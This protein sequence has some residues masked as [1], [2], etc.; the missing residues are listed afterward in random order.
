MD[1]TV[2]LNKLINRK[3]LTAEETESF[4]LEIINGTINNAQTGAILTALQMKG[5]TTEEIYGFIKAMRK[6]MVP[7]KLNNAIDVCG[8]GGDN[9]GSFNVSTTVA[10]VVAGAGVKVAKHGNRAA[11]SQCGS[12]DVLESLG[13]KINLNQEQTEEIFQKIGMVFLFAPLYHPAMKNIAI[14][15]KELK[16]KTI[17]NYL[18]PFVNPSL[19]DKQLI[20]VPN[21]EVAKKLVIVAK[22]LGYQ[23]I[24]IATSKD[25][26]DEIS[27][28][29]K[30]TL[31]ELKNKKIKKY[32]INPVNF[33]F[34]K[35][36]KKEISGGDI[37]E[38]A[39]IIRRILMGDKNAK[40]NIVV[41]NSGIALYLAGAAKNIKEGI[42]LAEKSIDRRKAKLVLDNLIKETQKYE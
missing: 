17:F 35:T 30:T 6:N 14:I 41:F 22:K 19:P 34:K 5:E 1:A 33:G 36:S 39:E 4:L 27:I 3:D 31:F 10:F 25:G 40:R 18:G 9:Y 2:I 37:K 42:K 13:V 32:T 21:E 15:R 24:V 26:M 28:A 29:C 7:I 8:T 12:A 23:H 11:S 16:V 38:N 20:G